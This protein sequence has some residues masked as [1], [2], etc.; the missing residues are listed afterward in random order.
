MTFQTRYFRKANF[1]I[2]FHGNFFRYVCISG[3]ADQLQSNY[4]ADFRS[5][6]RVVFSI[7]VSQ[8]PIEEEDEKAVVDHDLSPDLASEDQ[9]DQAEQDCPEAEGAAARVQHDR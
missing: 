8:D 7:N 1:E 4:A 3:A 5:I 6:L 9:V 2:Q